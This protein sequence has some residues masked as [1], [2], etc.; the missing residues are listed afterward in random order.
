MQDATIVEGSD[1][2]EGTLCMACGG[3]LALHPAV[4]FPLD[5]AP[6]LQMHI[7]CATSIGKELA[8]TS[9]QEWQALRGY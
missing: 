4:V 1:L 5:Y 7:T 6:S 2:P 8:K 9:V 3:R